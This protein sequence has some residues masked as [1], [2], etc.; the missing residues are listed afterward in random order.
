[1]DFYTRKAKKLFNVLLIFAFI[2]ILSFPA[3]SAP[4]IKKGDYLEIT[5][6]DQ[7]DFTRLVRVNGDGFIAYPYYSNQSVV[8][9]STSDLQ[10]ILTQVLGFYLD[11]PVV[12]VEKPKSFT[13]K[14]Q[15]VGQVNRPG[16][17]NIPYG[18]DIQSAI[19][20]AGG[21]LPGAN[22]AAVHV[23]RSEEDGGAPITLEADLAEFELSGDLTKL[24]LLEEY[25]IVV[26]PGQSNE[27][28]TMIIG[29]VNRPG[30]YPP[31]TDSNLM[32]MILTAG[33][34]TERAH[35]DKVRHLIKVG[36]G[37]YEDTKWDLEDLIDDGRFDELPMVKPGD[38]I[39]V[40]LYDPWIDWDITFEFLRDV[41]TILTIY[42]LVIR[43]DRLD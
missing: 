7:P 23:V 1:M 15:V 18:L 11:S 30:S 39:V 34:F 10:R 8:G 12:I 13:I 32:N 22:L 16:Q 9:N 35:Q 28:T 14:V 2:S 3:H 40:P 29:Q 5:V 31:K 33:G 20:M 41:V 43:I 42:L 25:D 36:P 17:Y 38:I 21:L 6:L 26:V 27:S 37:Q 4:L 24:P 19:G